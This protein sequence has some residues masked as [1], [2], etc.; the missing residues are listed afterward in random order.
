[1]VPMIL[2]IEWGI[3]RREER[4]LAAKFGDLYLNYKATVRRWM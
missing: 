1:M 2:I 3:I 4:Y